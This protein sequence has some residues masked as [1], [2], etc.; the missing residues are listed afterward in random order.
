MPPPSPKVGFAVGK[1]ATG[2]LPYMLHLAYLI[3]TRSFGAEAFH[4]EVISQ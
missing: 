3:R 1:L 4:S 2:Y